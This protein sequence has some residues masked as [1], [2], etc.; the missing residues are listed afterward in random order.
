MSRLLLGSQ[1][2]P[3]AADAGDGGGRRVLEPHAGA[4]Q[5]LFRRRRRVLEACVIHNK[6][7]HEQRQRE[8]PDNPP[9]YVAEDR[10]AA[11]LHAAPLNRKLLLTQLARFPKRPEQIVLNLIQLLCAA[12]LDAVP[13]FESEGDT[14]ILE[15]EQIDMGAR[16]GAKL[17]QELEKRL[18]AIANLVE[19]EQ[20]GAARPLAVCSP[21]SV[22]HRRIKEAAENE[23]GAEDVLR[24]HVGRPQPL[25]ELAYLLHRLRAQRCD[26]RLRNRRFQARRAR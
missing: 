26:V 13:A 8:R 12:I 5:Q 16:L 24:R 25:L 6:A 3:Q 21:R 9:G 15:L 7:D 19:L 1:Q 17:F 20:Q 23:T 22:E 14:Y 4:G 18:A 2:L 10:I 11:I